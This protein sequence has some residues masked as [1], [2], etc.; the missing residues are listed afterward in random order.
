MSTWDALG[1]EPVRGYD[2]PQKRIARAQRRSFLQFLRRAAAT[3]GHPV[4]RVCALLAIRLER[5]QKNSRLNVW[6][7]TAAFGRITDI[8]AKAVTSANT[9]TGPEQSSPASEATPSEG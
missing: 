6:Q 4:G 7:K 3:P 9:P 8:Y 1:Y 2:K 5:L